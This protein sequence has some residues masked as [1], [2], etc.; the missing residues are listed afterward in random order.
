V[1]GPAPRRRPTRHVRGPSAGAPSRA[2]SATGRFAIV[3][4]RFN[5]HI[6]TKLIDGARRVLMAARVP[7]DTIDLHWVPGSFELPQAASWLARSGRYAGIVCLGVVIKGETPHFDYV[8][9]EAATGIREVGLATGVPATFGVI[10][11]LDE[12]Q[13][14]DR[15]GGAVANR[16]E[17]AAAAVVEMVELARTLRGPRALDA[18][19][20]RA[21]RASRRRE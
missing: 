10:T 19:A 4:A 3:A 20:G 17:E 9:R 8:A 1:A 12:A 16:G 15:A 11:A 2:A 7:A 6:T 5:E 14:L 13:A 21:G 18:P